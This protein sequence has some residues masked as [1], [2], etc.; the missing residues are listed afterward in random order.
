MLI[1]DNGNAKIIMQL[2]K[3]FHK[4]AQA[5]IKEGN[6]EKQI[7]LAHTV[8]DQCTSAF[9]DTT[10]FTTV[11]KLQHDLKPDYFMCGENLTPQV[12]I[13]LNLD[14]EALNLNDAFYV[15]SQQKTVQRVVKTLRGAYGEY[16]GEP[17]ATVHGVD[18]DTA[19]KVG[20]LAGKT[21]VI[22]AIAT[23]L[24][25]FMNDR[26]T[27]NKYRYL[28]KWCAFEGDRNIPRKYFQSIA[29]TVGLIRGF[30]SVTQAAPKF[31]GLGM[32][33]PIAILLLGF[34]TYDCPFFAIDSSAPTKNASMGKLYVSEPAY[35]TLTVEKLARGL[36]TTN[37]WDCPCP[38]CSK[39]LQDYPMDYKAARIAFGAL[40]RADITKDDLMGSTAL[41]KALPLLSDPD[42]TKFARIIRT[43]RGGHN[44]WVVDNLLKKI[45][46]TRADYATLE[47]WIYQEV[48]KYDSH[49]SRLY[50]NS[51][52]EA[53]KFIKKIEL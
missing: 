45:E 25:G 2:G 12:L 22:K 23:G 3:L 14:R 33:S 34:V 9:N 27:T 5:A 28:G 38:H 41:A 17:F 35:L 53:L 40:K 43:A 13:E 15:K 29:V 26:Q 4:E 6:L 51:V 50:A 19:F 7:A 46:E 36:S 37:T 10:N 30:K 52:Y 32:G 16:S 44:Y 21:G 11:L 18:Y 42:D 20:K 8:L 31:H 48:A 47:A 1:A 24:A 49:A 39:F